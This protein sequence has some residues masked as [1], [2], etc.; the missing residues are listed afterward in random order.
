V[1]HQD[2]HHNTL[3]AYNT[4]LSAVAEPLLT[5]HGNKFPGTARAVSDVV[6]CPSI[7]TNHDGVECSVTVLAKNAELLY[8]ADK[9]SEMLHECCAY[10]PWPDWREF[11]RVVMRL[12]VGLRIF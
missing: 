11:R 4:P 12:D 2:R 9:A 8:V 10:R 3:A 1:D 7:K 6:S 5:F